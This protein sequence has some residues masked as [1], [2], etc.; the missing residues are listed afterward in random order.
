MDFRSNSFN[1]VWFLKSFV[2][3]YEKE[4]QTQSKENSNYVE[5]IWPE[6]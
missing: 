3:I 4:Y 1:L 2:S 6:I 5:T